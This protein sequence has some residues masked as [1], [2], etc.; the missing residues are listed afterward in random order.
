MTDKDP[1]EKMALVEETF[2]TVFK[3]AIHVETKR[4]RSGGTSSNIYVPTRFGN[5]PVTIII[6]DLPKDEE[7]KNE[8]EKIPE[9]LSSNHEIE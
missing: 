7:I 9:S 2:K 3:E 1:Y 5:H 4:V 8:S 6:W